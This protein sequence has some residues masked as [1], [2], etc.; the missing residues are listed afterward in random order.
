MGYEMKTTDVLFMI[1][2]LFLI[3]NLVIVGTY[4][5]Y[6]IKNQENQVTYYVIPAP[7]S[8]IEPIINIHQEVCINKTYSFTTYYTDEDGKRYSINALKKL[9]YDGDRA[10]KNTKLDY[11]IV[12]N[13]NLDGNF[14]VNVEFYD[15]Y[16][17]SLKVF[18]YATITVFA[19]QRKHS[20][21]SYS[22]IFSEKPLSAKYFRLKI[23]PP[24]KEE[25]I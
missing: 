8:Y 20:T 5:G 11:Y 18:N 17:T 14:I 6:R 10:D 4:I 13:E 16:N 23:I 19:N 25:C 9:Y 3:G 15:R 2:L 21:I 22:K 12:S 24:K 7:I 1:L